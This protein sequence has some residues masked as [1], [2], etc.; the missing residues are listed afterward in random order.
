MDAVPLPL[1]GDMLSIKEQILTQ[2]HGELLLH[3]LSFFA[4]Y[5]KQSVSKKCLRKNHV[6]YT[7]SSRMFSC[8]SLVSQ[9]L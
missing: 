8:F 6:N 4:Y 2:G 1:C 3:S 5:V 7:G 9:L